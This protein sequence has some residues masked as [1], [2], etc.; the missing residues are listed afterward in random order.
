MG[1]RKHRDRSSTRAEWSF[2]FRWT[3][4][5]QITSCQFKSVFGANAFGSKATKKTPFQNGGERFV[6]LPPPYPETVHFTWRLCPLSSSRLPAPLP[7]TRFRR[8]SR[9]HACLFRA[10]P[11]D[12]ASGSVSPG[13]GQVWVCEGRTDL[14]SRGVCGFASP[15][16]AS[17]IATFIPPAPGLRVPEDEDSFVAS[18]DVLEEKS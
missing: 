15:L 8:L 5:D 9:G 17:T 11:S 3:E 1:P 18:E 12:R 2:T 16:S 6:S 14:P 13:E 4:K 10:F 7:Q